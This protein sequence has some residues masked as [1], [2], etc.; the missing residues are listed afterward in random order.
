MVGGDFSFE[1]PSSLALERESHFLLA[2][3]LC[4]SC[5]Y[6]P[7][8]ITVTGLPYQIK[9]VEVEHGRLMSYHAKMNAISLSAESGGP[10]TGMAFAS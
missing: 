7:F 4:H 3:E 9:W 2:F 5:Q 8:Y 1:T 6:C 10:R